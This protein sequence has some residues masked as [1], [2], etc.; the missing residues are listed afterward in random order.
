[1]F[2][3]LVSQSGMTTYASL[4]VGIVGILGCLFLLFRSYTKPSKSFSMMGSMVSFGVVVVLVAIAWWGQSTIP[5]AADA[6][7]SAVPNKDKMTLLMKGFAVGRGHI[8]L[9]MMLGLFPLLSGIALLVRG[10]MQPGE[11]QKGGFV[12]SWIGAVCILVG[13]VM[14]IGALSALLQAE[15]LAWG[16]L[17]CFIP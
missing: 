10:L 9:A 16:L 6:A 5:S 7:V 12:F 15:E 4:G 13:C 17:I 1:M 3:E 2:E 8:V 14:G 11:Q